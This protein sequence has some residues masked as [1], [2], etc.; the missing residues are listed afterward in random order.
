MAR[1]Q[2]NV[3][4]FKYI[5][6]RSQCF[7]CCLQF[8]R[9]LYLNISCNLYQL[10]N[11]WSNW[12]EQCQYC[13]IQLIYTTLTYLSMWHHFYDN[14]YETDYFQVKWAGVKTKNSTTPYVDEMDDQ[15]KAML[16]EYEVIIRRWP[17]YAVVLEN[18]RFDWL[19]FICIK[20]KWHLILLRVVIFYIISLRHCQ[21]PWSFLVWPLH[22][23]CHIIN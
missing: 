13:I 15:L 12:N 23:P 9:L 16:N 20:L 6:K 3:I 17:E 10:A 19:F 7:R 22:W 18:V 8:A 5:S 11:Y 1:M 21:L 14:L 2:N 4:L